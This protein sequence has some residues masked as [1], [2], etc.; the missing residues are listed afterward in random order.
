MEFTETQESIKKVCES[1]SNFLLEKNKKYGN[2]A[3]DP[4]RL[5]VKGLSA[6]DLILVR[7]DD[8][9]N[10]IK[11][12]DT[13]KKNDIIDLAGYLVLLCV[14]KGWTAYDDISE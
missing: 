10:R 11:N 13:L 6:E 4:T 14:L 9:M 3:T 7:C 12:S 5:F 1:L 2:S 8:K